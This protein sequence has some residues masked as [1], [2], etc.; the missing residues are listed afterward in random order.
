MLRLEY[1]KA[2]EFLDGINQKD[3]VLIICHNDLD[4]IASGI[5]FYDFCRKKECNEIEILPLGSGIRNNSYV[6]I[7][8]FNK[9]L[10]ADLA[11]EQIVRDLESLPEKMEILY[12]DHHP[13][14]DDRKLKENITELRTT[15]EGYIPS[16][17]TVYELCGGKKWLAVIGVLSDFGD[18]DEINSEFIESF[19]KEI[20]KSIDYLRQEIMYTVSRAIIYSENHPEIEII[21][22]LLNMESLEDTRALDE[23]SEP[24]KREF[25]KFV[26]LF[27]QAEKISDKLTY[28]YF[29]PEYNI[30]SFIINFI[31][32]R[33]PSGIYI[34]ATPESDKI[35]GLSARSSSKEYNVAQILKDCTGDLKDSSAG[36]HFAAAGAQINRSDLDRFIEQLKKYDIEKVRL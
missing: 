25:D 36:G 29:E 8:K 3:S 2:K 10:V 28:Y 24:V 23:Y 34:F 27:D 16:S 1:Q 4:G 33:D 9:A 30:K 21:E 6:D 14:N 18:K 5:L 12:V 17:R 32:S 35:V 20:G 19:V 15:P 22:K 31:S 11:P 26:E 13:R 7:E